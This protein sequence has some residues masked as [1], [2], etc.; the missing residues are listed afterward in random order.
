MNSL[1]RSLLIAGIPGTGKT[2]VGQALE[3]D[4][5]FVHLDFEKLNVNE[6]IATDFEVLS[7]C[8]SRVVITW[9]FVPATTEIAA[10]KKLRQKGFALVWF[11]GNRKAARR[12]FIKRGDVP[13]DLLDLQ[14]ARIN[15]S[16]VLELF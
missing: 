4:Y 7:E 13:A 1:T 2:T 16:R 3:N 6:F 14:L 11:D 10:I 5:D 12:D 9:G 8:G 15:Q